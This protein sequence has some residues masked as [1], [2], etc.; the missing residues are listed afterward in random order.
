MKSGG[1]TSHISWT[2]GSR[3]GTCAYNIVTD[4]LT[5]HRDNAYP[6][7]RRPEL[8]RRLQP[9]E[10]ET[11]VRK[12]CPTY[13]GASIV[14]RQRAAPT[15]TQFIDTNRA[16]AFDVTHDKSIVYVESAFT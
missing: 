7:R 3:I 13:R 9:R 8:A 4:V 14:R 2:R 16:P 5:V 10:H 1:A 15:S 6:F 12:P 11:I